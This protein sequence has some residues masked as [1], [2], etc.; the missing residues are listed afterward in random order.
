MARSKNSKTLGVVMFGLLLSCLGLQ[1]Q[2]WQWTKRGGGTNELTINLPSYRTEEVFSIV[3]DSEKNSYVL[4]SLGRIS[5]QIEGV[6]ITTYNDVTSSNDVVLASFSCSGELRWTKVFGGSGLERLVELVIDVAG[7]V[8]VAGS[9]NSCDPLNQKPARIGTDYIFDQTQS[10]CSPHFIAK[11]SSDGDFLWI[12]R[13]QENSSSLISLGQNGSR[14]GLQVDSQGNLYWLMGCGTGVSFADGAFVNNSDSRASVVFKYD[15]EGNF[16]SATTL[17]GVVHNVGG[18]NFYRNP[19]NGY[20]YITGNDNANSSPII[21]GGE[22]MSHTSF[23]ACFNEQGQ[24]QW[25]RQ[26]TGTPPGPY[27]NFYG[28]E[29]DSENNIYTGGR[30]F[31]LNN[32]TFLG[33][34]NTG[35]PTGFI[36]KLN[37]T[38][39]Q[40]IWHSLSNRDTAGYGALTSTPTEVVWGGYSFQN[41]TWSGLSQTI[42]PPGNG[43]RPTVVTFNKS[44]GAATSIIHMPAVVGSTGL[45][46]KIAFDASGDMLVGG[47]FSGTLTPTTSLSVPSYGGDSDFFLAKWA[48]EV[49]S[50]LQTESFDRS[51]LFEI[52][53]NPVTDVLLLRT[54]QNLGYELRNIHGSVVQSG[55]LATGSH[56]LNCSSLASGIYLLK[57]TN[58]QGQT[59][60]RKVVVE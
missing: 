13:P 59:S 3:S 15:T 50:P 33:V 9:F 20:Y 38:A 7:N 27:I 48:T 25:M 57:A 21:Y 24:F 6:P 44:T 46:T 28:L 49:C 35:L 52:G 30:F 60:I 26:D 53:S 45:V 42:G 55:S 10:S 54:T 56:Q 37:P 47:K 2:S 23:I 36:M 29:F 41:I 43:T 14:G 4:S 22:V 8:Y 17:E 51:E 40:V 5:P 11:F 32:T 31:G 12:R 16:L 58:E 39:D 34:S 19:Y 1:A 18:G